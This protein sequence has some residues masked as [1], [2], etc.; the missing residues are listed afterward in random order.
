VSSDAAV[1]GS[2]YVH[3]GTGGIAAIKSTI[4]MCVATRQL[5]WARRLV[6]GVFELTDAL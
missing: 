5:I 2:R 6:N 3:R 1:S 4:P